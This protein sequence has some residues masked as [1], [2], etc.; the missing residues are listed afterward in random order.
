M[1]AKP[2]ILIFIDWFLPGFK[3]GGPIKSVTN[4]VNSLYND[5]DFYIITSDRDIDD[6][7]PY[8]NELMSQWVEKEHYKIAYL[9][10]ETRKEFIV[11][12]LQEIEF[13]KFYFNSLYSKTYTL[14]PFQV[15]KKLKLKTKVIIAPRG[16][17]GKGARQIKS[18]K[19]NTFLVLTKATGFF[20]SITWHATDEE[21]KKDIK[22]IIGRQSNVVLVPNISILKINKKEIKKPTNELRLVFFSRIASKKNLF[23]AL[24]IINKLK[25]KNITLDIFG[26]IEDVEYWKKCEDFISKNKL[27]VSYL[28]KLNP[29]NVDGTLSK[30][31]FLFLPTLHENYGHVIVEALTAGCGLILSTNTPWRNLKR[32][33][34]GC[35]ISLNKNEQF[36]N[37]INRFYQMTQEEYDELRKC[38]YRFI[39][40]EI[41]K[42]NAIELTKNMFLL[43]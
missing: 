32:I 1:T 34:I 23:Y 19:K 14:Q 42:Q 20:N 35:D 12:A 9:S 39:S 24:E 21:E 25:D 8:E 22:T 38:C 4:I 43:S 5:F 11:I 29:E 33:N 18:I 30:Y 15:I 36:I 27:K 13:S 2:K 31:H 17:M 7:K 6:D 26:S 10:E 3:A 16:M 37:E 40:D 28:G 41:E